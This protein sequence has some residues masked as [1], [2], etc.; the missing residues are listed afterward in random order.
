ML[1]S[2]FNHA[3]SGSRG[4]VPG[5]LKELEGQL[6]FTG[7]PSVASSMGSSAPYPRH[8]LTRNALDESR[9]TLLAVAVCHTEERCVDRRVRSAPQERPIIF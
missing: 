9:Q 3:S 5:S 1:F 4:Q 6:G 8:Y 7:A 2:A